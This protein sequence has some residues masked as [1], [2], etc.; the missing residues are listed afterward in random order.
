MGKPFVG[1]FVPCV[2]SSSVDLLKQFFMTPEG[3]NFKYCIPFIDASRFCNRRDFETQP[4]TYKLQY[5]EL[6]ISS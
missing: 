3:V 5:A 1:F 4:T 6:N 2:W